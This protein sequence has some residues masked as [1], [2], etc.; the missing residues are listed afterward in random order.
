MFCLILNS[1]P[2]L[3]KKFLP[4]ALSD[5][6]L[7]LPDTVA[8]GPSPKHDGLKICLSSG[9]K[10]DIVDLTA[11]EYFERV[12]TAENY[13]LCLLGWLVALRL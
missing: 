4:S 12:V 5:S 8:D 10:L 6:I 13:I 11:Q 9:H 2:R 1:N 3:E 7:G